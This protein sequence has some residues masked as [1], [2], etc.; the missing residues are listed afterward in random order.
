MLERHRELG[1]PGE[2]FSEALVERELGRDELERHD[3]L[4]AQVVGA[5]DDAHAALSDE[6]V[7]P[8]AEELV[9]DTDIRSD[10]HHVAA[11]RPTIRPAG[12]EAN[13]GA[14]APLSDG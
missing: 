10:T 11:S 3:S 9:S 8:V 4:Q 13:A 6:L 14:E 2:A 7:D 1:L 12:M 5:I